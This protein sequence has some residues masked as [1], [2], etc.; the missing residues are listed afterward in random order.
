M[1]ATHFTIILAGLALLVSAASAVT[2]KS[3]KTKFDEIDVERINVVEKNGRL[4][5]VISNRERQHPGVVDGVLMKRPNGR[6]P[7]IIFFNQK[8][9][10]CGGLIF[11]E[12]GKNGHFVSLTMDKFRNDQTIGMQHL[13]G[14]DGRYFAGFRV[15]ER[16]NT[17]L[18]DR[19]VR[20]EAIDKLTDEAI[21]KAAIDKLRQEGEF[22]ASRITVGRVRSGTALI[23]LCDA[24]GRPR[25]RL[26]VDAD[27]NAGIEFLDEDGKVTGH[28]PPS[29]SGSGD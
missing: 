10:E 6:P 4:R 2:Q 15:W 11:D 24:K 25:L 8:G 29:P 17:S 26:A 20:L 22:G 23:S 28:Y 14:S 27:G 21:R 3:G 1:K 9:D 16:P 5:M 12:N 19:Q 18:A 7:G 13:E